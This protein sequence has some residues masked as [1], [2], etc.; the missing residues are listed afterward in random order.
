MEKNKDLFTAKMFRT[1]FWPAM[2]S[3]LGWALSDMADAVVVGQRL[4]ATGLAAISLILP[5]YMINCMLAHG[6]GL[7][8]SVLFSLHMSTGKEQEARRGFNSVALMA[9]IFSS[10]TAVLGLV[11]MKQLLAVLGAGPAGTALYRATRRYLVVL[12]SSTPLF[13]MSNILNYYLR[14][15][16]AERAA[17]RG[18]VVGNLCD[19]ALNLLLVLVLGLGTM[20]AALATTLGQIISISIYLPAVLGKKS[21]LRPCAPGEGWAKTAMGCLKGG[22]A[23]SVQYLYQMIFFLYCNNMLMRLGGENTVAVF[24]VIQNTSYLILYLYQGTARAMQPLLTTYSGERNRTGRRSTVKI[25][26]L[27]GILAGSVIII[28]IELFPGLICS[29]FGVTEASIAAMTST[30]LRIYCVGAFFAGLN[31]L[32]SNINESCGREKTAFAIETCR[33]FIFLFASALVLSRFGIPAFWWLF[34][35]T[36]FLTLITYALLRLKKSFA[37]PVIDEK[38]VMQRLAGGSAEQVMDVCREA[39]EFCDGW[40]AD[41]K[42]TLLVDMVLEELGMAILNH[43]MTREDGYLQIAIVAPEEGGFEIHLRDNGEA[44]DPFS[45]ETEKAGSGNDFNMDA[46]GILMIRKKV[47]DFKYR[48]YHGFNTLVIKV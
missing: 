16:N 6:F 44:F 10:A 12:V 7:G 27:S 28:I 5:V 37:L 26:M 22:I 11:F 25:G 41:M 3:S 33:G 42:Q 23:S 15:D 2:A 21:S 36:E 34:F 29:L 13:Y 48:H 35:T 43:A 14:N 47:K 31:I 40:G 9:L 18:S 32:Y 30:A 4:G 45:L 20:G 17:A 38:R 39:D 46:M 24:D 1:L 8:G 19:I